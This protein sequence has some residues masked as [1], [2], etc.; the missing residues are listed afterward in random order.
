LI[1]LH[2]TLDSNFTSSWISPASINYF[3][4]LYT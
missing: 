3:E 1:T 4:C 2:S